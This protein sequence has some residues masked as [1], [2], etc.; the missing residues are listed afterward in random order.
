MAAKSKAQLKGSQTMEFVQ[1][2]RHIDALALARRCMRLGARIPTITLITGLR[3]W[4]V[5][6]HLR[7]HAPKGRMP[8]WIR[9]NKVS[10]QT[11]EASVFAAIFQSIMDMKICEANLAFITAYE[12]F[13]YQSP[14]RSNCEGC[15]SFDV[16]FN[17]I[18]ELK[19]IWTRKEPELVLRQCPKCAALCL[20]N[21]YA[22]DPR[23]VGCAFCGWA[24][25]FFRKS[26]PASG[27]EISDGSR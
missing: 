1:L 5:A 24:K 11:A 23:G 7:G 26:V 14:R 2:D 8:L 4:E 18:C 27:T 15:L 16:A 22:V 17:L 9:W 12:V 20:W 10:K 25:S 21:I 3:H 13:Q 6:N 19:G